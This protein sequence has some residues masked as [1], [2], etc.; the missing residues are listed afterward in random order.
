LERFN[1][2]VAWSD[3]SPD[4]RGPEN[5]DIAVTAA[6]NDEEENG[7]AQCEVEEEISPSDDSSELIELYRHDDM[8]E[9][10]LR[11]WLAAVAIFQE[12]GW[13]LGWSPIYPIETYIRP[14]G[15][16]TED[17]GKAMQRAGRSLFTKIAA[18]PA[19]SVSVPMDLGMFYRLTEFVG[20]GAFIVGRQGALPMQMRTISATPN[21]TSASTF[22]KGKPLPSGFLFD[23]QF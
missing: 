13:S 11:E 14:L 6:D 17:E 19:F 23:R 16:V 21:L 10:G 12:G 4:L 7:S 2:A 1:Q 15:F 20:G 8:V 5:D 3:L 18:E 22:L 9:I